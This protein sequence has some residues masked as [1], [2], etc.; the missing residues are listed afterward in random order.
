M[1]EKYVMID[2]NDARSVKIAEVISNKTC[3][4]ILGALAER[5][6]SESEI[7]SELDIPLN[8][9]GYNVK[10][11]VEAGLI[12][13]SNKFFWSAK[14]RRINSYKISNKKIVISPKMV[15]KGIIPALLI[16]F[17]LSIGIKIFVGQEKIDYGKETAVDSFARSAVSEGEIAVDK[18]SESIAS[19]GM[20]AARSSIGEPAVSEI[21]GNSAR[22]AVY[23][24]LS[25]APN[26]W[27]WF[28]I[29]ALTALA[30]YLFWN[31]GKK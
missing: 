7:A 11:L 5:E 26:S 20:E 30:V 27:A 12:E 21:I 19:A 13:K 4:N 17:L 10:K 15:S 28:L 8:T 24:T 2:M 6:M 22:T 25:N 23:D 29:G 9:V 14:G 31:W 3:K 1:S 18:V 16:T